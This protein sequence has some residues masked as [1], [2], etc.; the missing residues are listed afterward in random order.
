MMMS[1]SDS[2]RDGS[3]GS[4]SQLV[5]PAEPAAS[6]PPTTQ[7]AVLNGNG[8]PAPRFATRADAIAADGISKS[9]LILLGSGLAVAVLFFVFTAVV[10]KSPKKQGLI[11][12]ANQRAKK[13]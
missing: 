6:Q 3:A 4:P 10:S 12:P 11:K 8:E 1:V 9:K 13:E 7:S 2:N 5:E